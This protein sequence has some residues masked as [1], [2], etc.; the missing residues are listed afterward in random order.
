MQYGPDYTSPITKVTTGIR[1][2][3]YEVQDL[4]P[5]LHK[6]LIHKAPQ[7]YILKYTRERTR[8]RDI[9]EFSRRI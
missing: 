4:Q 1:T 5:H 8:L 7:R 9:R 6:A 2:F 3:V